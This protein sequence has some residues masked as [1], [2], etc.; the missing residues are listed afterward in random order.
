MKT[1]TKEDVRDGIVLER[2]WKRAR[3]VDV[4]DLSHLSLTQLTHQLTLL[5]SITE[6]PKESIYILEKINTFLSNMRSGN[7]S[8]TQESVVQLHR[9]LILRLPNLSKVSFDPTNEE[10]RTTLTLL[11]HFFLC[12][13]YA[14]LGCKPLDAEITIAF[15]ILL[16]ILDNLKLSHHSKDEEISVVRLSNHEFYKSFM[17]LLDMWFMNGTDR[18]FPPDENSQMEDLILNLLKVIHPFAGKS[19][20]MKSTMSDNFKRWSQCGSIQAN[21]RTL[22]CI[23]TLLLSED[24]TPT[25]QTRLDSD[26]GQ[27]R[28]IL[29]A[30][31]CAAFLG[32]SSCLKET[33]IEQLVQIVST[34]WMKEDGAELVAG[35]METIRFYHDT[36]TD[37]QVQACIKAVSS[38]TQT[39]LF[40]LS[41]RHKK[42]TLLCLDAL[43]SVSREDQTAKDAEL[44]MS[45]IS[46][47]YNDNAFASSCPR[48]R[49]SAA[50]IFFSLTA[51]ML[52]C[53]CTSLD[54]TKH[55]LGILSELL[56]SGQPEVVSNLTGHLPSFMENRDVRS[57]IINVCPNLVE[58]LVTSAS[59]IGPQQTLNIARTLWCIL[60][61]DRFTNRVARQRTVVATIVSFAAVPSN[62]TIESMELRRIAMHSLFTLS[63]NPCNRRVLANHPGLLASMIQ[64]VR[65]TGSGVEPNEP[66]NKISI[67]DCMKQQIV[68]LAKSL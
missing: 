51:R 15:P 44:E 9:S 27:N 28:E 46:T 32:L 60:S 50:S 1:K 5:K 16:R 66:R 25:A 31:R 18:Q 41:N 38:F 3:S 37:K 33:Q 20:S 11:C 56:S 6:N 59:Y 55:L 35:A 21:S 49:T 30:L 58:S 53:S 68:L 24:G 7:F 57:S 34:G 62:T 12:L 17:D 61:D 26:V 10:S 63:R 8:A 65:G 67:N 54:A 45:L 48:T 19:N 29:F 40:H 47:L 64:Y 23:A 36:F 4:D 43:L 14:Y 22:F 52:K 2:P 42:V 13:R 39:E